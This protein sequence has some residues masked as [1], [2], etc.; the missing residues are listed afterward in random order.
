M[1]SAVRYSASRCWRASSSNRARLAAASWCAVLLAFGARSAVTA[2]SLPNAC[3]RAAIPLFGSIDVRE[4]VR[5]AFL[6]ASICHA[7]ETRVVAEI[8]QG[9][10]V[11]IAHAAAQS[12]DE[13]I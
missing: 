8:A 1:R 3:E 13:L 4:V 9:A 7:D 11:Q 2:S 5:L 10:R 12:A 6:A